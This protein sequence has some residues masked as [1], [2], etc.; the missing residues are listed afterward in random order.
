MPL[1]AMRKESYA[2]A[3]RRSVLHSRAL[4][5]LKRAG[6]PPSLTASNYSWRGCC[7]S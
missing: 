7:T 5:R 3:E 1:T 6:V 4:Q 2:F